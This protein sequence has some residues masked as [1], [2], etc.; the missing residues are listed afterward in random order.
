MMNEIGSYGGDGRPD[1]NKMKACME[2]CGKQDFGEEEFT[3]MEHYAIRKANRMP[4]R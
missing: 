4:S 2:Q 3:V 1:I